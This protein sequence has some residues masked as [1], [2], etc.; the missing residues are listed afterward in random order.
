M[1][2][3]VCAATVRSILRQGN[4][5]PA[6]Q[7]A[8]DAWASY[9]RAQASGLPACDFFHV[10]TALCRRLYVLFAMEVATRQ[11]HVHGISAHP[12][13]DWMTQQVRHPMA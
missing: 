2:I 13:Q 3:T 5:P 6:P 8:H 12:N 10:D 4:I 9:L 11:V 7:R 1:G